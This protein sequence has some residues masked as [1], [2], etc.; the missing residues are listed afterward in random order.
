MGLFLVVQFNFLEV[1]FCPS[2]DIRYGYYYVLEGY[3]VWGI[4]MYYKDRAAP[5]IGGSALDDSGVKTVQWRERE[6]HDSYQEVE[7]CM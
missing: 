3:K 4:I 1:S 5:P 6:G 7:I 2:P